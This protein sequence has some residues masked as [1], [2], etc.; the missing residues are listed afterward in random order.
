MPWS[1]TSHTFY[2]LFKNLDGTFQATAS[3]FCG[4]WTWHGKSPIFLPLDQTAFVQCLMMTM[5]LLLIMIMK[6]V[7]PN[8][9]RHYFSA[10]ITHVICDSTTNNKFMDKRTKWNSMNACSECTWTELTDILFIKL[11]DKKVS[12]D[13]GER[14]KIV[15]AVVYS[16]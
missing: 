3:F 11:K 14:S 5:L 8:S 10:H 15:G 7:M 16:A 12:G 4:S 9:N 1:E 6:R 13:K 2:M